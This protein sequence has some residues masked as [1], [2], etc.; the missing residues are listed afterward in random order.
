M[1]AAQVVRSATVLLALCARHA[2]AQEPG[3]GGIVYPPRQA[4]MISAP[5]GWIR[6][7]SASR[8]LAVVFY[9]TGESWQDGDAVMYLNTVVP[10]SG[11]QAD[12]AQ[13]LREDSL[14]FNLLAPGVRVARLA[15]MRTKDGRLAAVQRFT[16]DPR[17][18]E[19]LP[20]R[21]FVVLAYVQDKTV[22][23][24]LVLSARTHAAFEAALPA[25]RYLVSSYSLVSD[26]ARSS[27]N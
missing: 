15:L 24:V 4:F 13:E 23:P 6:D 18:Y 17:T 12:P 20:S 26:S 14:R 25:F 7:T 16:P 8:M 19:G 1:R 9:R 27:P 3:A 10:D 5:P 21:G 2:L 11:R 22:T